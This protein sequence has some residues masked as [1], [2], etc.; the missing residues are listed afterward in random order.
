MKLSLA[1][2]ETKT[3][4]KIQWNSRK[5]IENIKMNKREKIAMKKNV[6]LPSYMSIV[7][8]LESNQK[9]KNNMIV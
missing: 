7:Y 8:K 2:G 3:K 9:N 1:N 6:F 4:N 5:K